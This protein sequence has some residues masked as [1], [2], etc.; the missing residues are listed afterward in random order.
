MPTDG[1]SSYH[2]IVWF[3][4]N[5]YVFPPNH[6]VII[7]HDGAAD[8]RLDGAAAH[9]QVVLHHRGDQWIAVDRGGGGMYVGGVRMSTVFIHDG[10]RITLGDPQHGPLLIF[11]FVAL[12][13]PPPRP[14]PAPPPPAPPTPPR[15]RAA[16]IRRLT[17]QARKLLPQKTEAASEKAPS[18]ASR[19][20][21]VVQ[22]LVVATHK[23]PNLLPQKDKDRPSEPAPVP[24]PGDG[25]L[26]VRRVRFS[27]DGHQALADVSFTAAPGTLTA[28]IGLSEASTSALAD[29]LGGAVQPSVG[30]VEF[31]GHAVAADHIRPRVAAVPRHDLLHPQLTLEQALHY[32]AEL[33]FAPDTSAERRDE[34]VRSVLDEMKLSRVRT[35]QLKKLTAEQRK[36]ASLA[37]E[38]LTD[39]ALLVLDEPTAGLEPEAKQQ[40]RET[41][42]RLADDGRVVVVATTSHADL[43]GCDQVLILTP[44][45]IPVFAGPPTQIA[46]DLGTDDWTEIVARVSADPYGAHDEYLARHQATTT[47][48]SAEAAP[49]KFGNSEP[50][51]YPNVWRQIRIAIKR[52]AW[53]VAADQR[54]LIFLTILPVLFGAIALLM[55]G[56]AGLGPAS[57]YGNSPDEAVAIL[58]V[59]NIG[60]VAM[61]TALGIRDLFG[62]SRI[63]R[64]EQAHG[65][66]ATAFLTAKVVV[67]AIV[68][69]VQTSIITVTAAVGKGA[70]THGAVLL[71]NATF[72]LFVILAVTTVVSAMVALAISAF[73][74]YFEQVLLT[75]VLIVF[76]S[77]V[78]AGALF[79]V[80]GRFGLEQIAWFVPARWSFAALASTVDV[81]AVNLLAAA[82]SSWKH[83]AGPWLRDMGMLI[84]LGAI[85]T[86]ALR[87]GL[88]RLVNRPAVTELSQA[89]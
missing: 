40:L 51:T 30:T 6:D 34:S 28:V 38:L 8:I 27:A 69:I 63:F 53:L 87:W 56:P 4:S 44:T 65:L 33:R 42:R 24:A 20:G 46:A 84:G 86:G 89:P 16:A 9:T 32:A 75:A 14:A 48:P 61:G 76:A 60:A 17:G 21:A 23:L 66:S 62:E 43:E 31:G 88:R 41:L 73:A 77:L 83:A 10:R 7:G 50:P 45:G 52:Q 71:G 85:A 49:Q 82:D 74:S 79:P 26:E 58:A 15:D 3:G 55:P 59:L 70:P 78:F 18:A 5:R 67:Y 13:T 37:V 39:P 19:R 81:H 11:Q 72:E 29:V 36:H 22:R 68:A 54:Y 2:L 35:V 47:E 57:P 64:R 25:P 80:A 12:P 1:S